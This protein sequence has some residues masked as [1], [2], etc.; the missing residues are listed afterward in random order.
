MK[1]NWFSPFKNAVPDIND[2]IV[3]DIMRGKDLGAPIYNRACQFCQ[4]E[5]G[6]VANFEDL[7]QDYSM[8]K[9]M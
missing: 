9:K 8:S 2:Q 1:P 5:F 4:I 3:I 7:F 6:S